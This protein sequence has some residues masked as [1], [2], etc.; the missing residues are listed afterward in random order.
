MR[1]QDHLLKSL[2]G[3]ELASYNFAST[4]FT[5]DICGRSMTH[6]PQPRRKMRRKLVG[7]VRGI[8]GRSPK[9]DTHS[10]TCCPTSPSYG[11]HKAMSS[12]SKTENEKT[13][14]LQLYGCLRIT[15]TAI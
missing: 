12:Q 5:S 11:L 14:A 13:S 2:V 10:L 7:Q 1:S 6:S 15:S 8:A 4:S 3:L 9:T